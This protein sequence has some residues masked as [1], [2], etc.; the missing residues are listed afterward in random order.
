MPSTQ[1]GTGIADVRW[2]PVAKAIGAVGEVQPRPLPSS[3]YE[4]SDFYEEEE[5]YF[6]PLRKDY[7]KVP[8]LVEGMRKCTRPKFIVSDEM[9]FRLLMVLNFFFRAH[10]AGSIVRGFEE[11]VKFIDYKKSP[12][13]PYHYSCPDKGSALERFDIKGITEREIEHHDQEVIYDITEKDELRPSAKFPRVFFPAPFHATMVGNMLFSDMNERLAATRQHHPMKLGVQMPGAEFNK[14]FTSFPANWCKFHFDVAGFDTHVSLSVMAVIAHFR[15]SMVDQ[16]HRKAIY[17]YYCKTYCGFAKLF[18]WVV[19]LFIQFSGQTNTFTDNALYVIAV[20][21]EAACSLLQM[22]LLDVVDVVQ[23]V[24]GSDD[25]MFAVHPDF[26]SKFN[27]LT[28]SNYLFSNYGM[29]LESPSLTPVSILDLYFF[30]H[31]LVVRDLVEFQLP[32]TLLAI[33]NVQKLQSGFSWNTSGNAVDRL[34]RYLA[35]LLCLY[36]DREIFEKRRNQVNLW[37]QKQ[38]VA[39]S[40]WRSLVSLL[41]Y[42]QFFL[43]VHISRRM[44]DDVGPQTQPTEVVAPILF[45]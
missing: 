7:L 37:V 43:R 11:C 3:K 30:S 16:R 10:L 20:F 9:Q 19:A 29:M 14:L 2:A 38:D 4:P 13:H 34:Q 36:P 17:V 39:E 8:G 42:D 31:H 32:P 40:L 22:S 24:D 33:G 27:I 26:V 25:G 12:G 21:F 1:I 23:L 35:L 18:G 15:G 41:N 28:L 5:G 44:V 6:P 45:F